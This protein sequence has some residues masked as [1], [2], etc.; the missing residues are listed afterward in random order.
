M[1]KSASVPV[2]L[3]VGSVCVYACTCAHTGA[4][5]LNKVT[6]SSLALPQASERCCSVY[7]QFSSVGGHPRG[8]CVWAV[9]VPRSVC[10]SRGRFGLD[11]VD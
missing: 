1:T 11:G 6:E 10:V 3:R 5:A 7:A 2:G 8:V 4:S 9:G